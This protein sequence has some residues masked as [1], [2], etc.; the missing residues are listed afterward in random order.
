MGADADSVPMIP[1]SRLEGFHAV[2]APVQL[3]KAALLWR[4]R[5]LIGTS[6]LLNREHV[7]VKLNLKAGC[8]EI[9]KHGTLYPLVNLSICS[10]FPCVTAEHC[11]HAIFELEVSVAGLEVLVFEFNDEEQRAGFAEALHKSA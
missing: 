4:R 6:V 9:C 10:V 1:P 7:R 5:L 2:P 8:L 11:D 3:S